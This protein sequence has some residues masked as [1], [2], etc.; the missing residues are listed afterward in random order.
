[1]SSNFAVIGHPIAHTMSPFI[2]SRLFQLSGR[3]ADYGVMNIAP[4]ELAGKMADLKALDGFNIT[5]PHKQAIIPYL[6]SLD[7]KAEFFNSVNTVK[8]TGNRLTG[9]TTD[10]IG[11]C[12]ALEAASADLAGR[13]V[14]LGAGG[15]ARVMAFEAALKGGRVTIATRAHSQEA[16]SCLCSDLKSKVNGAN[17]DFCLL[18]S[19][20]GQIDLLANATPVGMYP[21]TDGCPVEERIIRQLK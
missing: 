13:T 4:E 1:M 2:H 6:D 18:E 9:Y 20:E 15:A 17:V 5:I 11:F 21:N 12:K 19:I 7:K 10:G 3:L 14:I 8:N 16:A